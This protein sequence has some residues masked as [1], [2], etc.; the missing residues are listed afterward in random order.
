MGIG[1]KS[2]KRVCVRAWPS[3]CVGPG[4]MGQMQM[5]KELGTPGL[6]LEPTPPGL[7]ARSTGKEGAGSPTLG[8]IIAPFSKTQRE[9][10]AG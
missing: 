2:R 6:L 3:G 10:E 5:R 4:V 7:A 1:E 9:V 8:G